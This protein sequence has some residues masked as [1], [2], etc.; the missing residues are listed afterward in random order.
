[1]LHTDWIAMPGV[2]NSE[3]QTNKFIQTDNSS[4]R[5]VPDRAESGLVGVG[6][7]VAAEQESTGDRTPIEP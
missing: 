3:G 4:R 1:M 2:N 7:Q 6:E 5:I